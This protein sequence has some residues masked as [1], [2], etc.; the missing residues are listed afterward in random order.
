M[1]LRVLRYFVEVAHQA[2]ITHAAA[3]HISQPTLS[4]QL[5]ALED[6]M[7]KKLFERS[8]YGITLTDAGILMRKRAEDILAMAEKNTAEFAKMT[9]VTGG[10]LYIGCAESRLIVFLA[11]SIREFRNSYP[12][13]RFHLV[14]GDTSTVIEKLNQALIDLTIIAEFGQ[15]HLLRATRR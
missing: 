8:N 1:E 6:E 12:D 13:V 11:T 4:K 15:I 3:L 5:K 7:G 2:S 9:A 10:D 14:S